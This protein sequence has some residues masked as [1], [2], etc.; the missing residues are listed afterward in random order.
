M[1]VHLRGYAK[2]K[3][4]SIYA[5]TRCSHAPKLKMAKTTSRTKPPECILMSKPVDPPSVQIPLIGY[6]ASQPGGFATIDAE[7]EELVRSLGPWYR[8][9]MLVDG[10]R[11]PA[12][13][14]RI[15]VEGDPVCAWAWLH[16]FVMTIPDKHIAPSGDVEIYPISGWWLDCRKSNLRVRDKSSTKAT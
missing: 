15:D 12:A 9:D 16:N 3:G 7:H 1:P 14:N 11:K 8:A 2:V 10:Q 5:G 13:R 6:T 4:Q